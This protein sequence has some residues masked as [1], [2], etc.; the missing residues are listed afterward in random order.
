[1]CIRDRLAQRTD[2]AGSASLTNPAGVV[3][4]L[5]KQIVGAVAAISFT[6]HYRD[7]RRGFDQISNETPLFINLWYGLGEVAG[8]HMGIGAYGSVGTAFDFAAD[9]GQDTP[10]LGKLALV[11]VGFLAG[12]QITPDLRVGLQIAPNYAEQSVKLPS[13]LGPVEFEG[14]KGAGIDGAL[15]LVYAPSEKL[16]LGLSYRTRG[17]TRLEG[18]GHVGGT[19]QDLV[20]DLYTPQSVT[21]AFDYEAMPGLHIMGQT[22]WTRY[23]DFESGH[24]DFEKSDPLDQPYIANAT[25]RFRHW[26]AVEYTGLSNRVLRIGYTQEPWMIEP[27]A[28]RPTLFDTADKMLMVGYE[29]Q[30]E[31]YNIGFTYGYTGGRQRDISPEQNPNFAGNYHSEIRTGFGVHFTWKP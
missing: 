10:F 27:D 15:G 13:P 2:D 7:D 30:Y 25:N 12:R 20:L 22:K 4:P 3:G 9:G 24:F 14:L 18:D 31:S 26:L 5:S 16:S 11:N 6:A 23:D 29:M 8:W 28:V 21:A 19:K 1:M 17:Y